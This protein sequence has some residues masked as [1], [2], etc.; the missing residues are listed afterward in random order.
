MQA[1]EYPDNPARRADEQDEE[2]PLYHRPQRR[3]G[4][5]DDGSYNP[6]THPSRGYQN[7]LIP[8]DDYEPPRPNQ[9]RSPQALGTHGQRPAETMNDDVL[10]A[11]RTQRPTQDAARPQQSAAPRTGDYTRGYARP[12]SGAARPDAGQQTPSDVRAPQSFARTQR[13]EE[14][15][16]AFV[17]E[18]LDLLGSESDL[19]QKPRQSGFR[20]NPDAAQ[21]SDRS[22]QEPPENNPPKWR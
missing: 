18:Q 14:S 20:L 19:R 1:A 9:T 6:D 22:A 2:K 7:P 12:E 4:F 17:S 21:K 10:F 16:E 5:S 11:P 3:V 13:A 8:P 15:D